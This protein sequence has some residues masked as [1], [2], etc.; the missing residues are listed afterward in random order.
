MYREIYELLGKNGRVKSAVIVKGE[1]MGSRCIFSEGRCISVNGS[2]TDWSKYESAIRDTSDTRM[3][4]FGD[5]DIFVEIYLKNPRLVILG[6]GHVSQPVAHIGK[7]LGFHVTV[8][9]DREGFLNRERF[10]DAD[11]LVLGSFEELSEKIPPYENAYYV[12][13]TR[14][15]MGDTVCARQ[16]LKR[17]Y[18]YFGMIGSKN[19]VRLTREKL[20][21][22]G[23]S[24]EALDTV[25]S[26]I[27]L[28][29]GGQLPEEI[30]VSILAQIIQ[31]KN[32]NY[33]A[34]TDERV[35]EAVCRGTC[36]VM[37][38][39]IKKSGSSPRG[40]GSKMLIGTDGTCY[41]SIGGG[42]VEYEAQKEGQKVDTVQIRN[43]NL[44]IN[45]DKNLGM[46]CGGSVEVLF[47]RVF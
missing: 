23:F 17:P 32:K 2:G 44:S 13:I 34:F 5:T 38:T 37:A 1:G 19:K 26:P 42:T 35:A 33:T 20:L 11:E 6:A 14:G 15:H 31:V 40:A 47:E 16:I 25:Y 28:P 18:A 45:D 36:G 12:V 9:D 4:S 3:L 39:I 30:A 8:M 21:G 43:Y 46:I 7:L 10:P 24:E 29:I 22:E 27:G 41:G